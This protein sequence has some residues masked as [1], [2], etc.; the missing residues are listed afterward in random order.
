MLAL[1]CELLHCCCEDLLCD[2]AVVAGVPPHK[3]AYV[4]ELVLEMPQP[5]WEFMHDK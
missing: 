4:S 1:T 2:V 5:V 3:W